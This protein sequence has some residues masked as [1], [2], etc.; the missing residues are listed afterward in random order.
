VKAKALRRAEKFREAAAV[1]ARAPRD[2]ASLVR[3]DEWWIERRLV[4]RELLDAG[5][6]K[7]A[8][9]IAAGYAAQ[10]DQTAMEAEFHAGWI[11]LRFLGDG[12]L[13]ARHF[14]NLRARAERPISV[15]RGAYWQG[16]AAEMMGDR[17]GAERYYHEAAS[18]STTYYGQI[19]RARLGLP[20]VALRKLP[21]PSS[22]ARA[23][24][25]GLLATRSIEMLY[26]LNEKDLARALVA[27]MA[28]MLQEG[29]KLAML[30]DLTL[31]EKDTRAALSVGKSATQRGFPLE[32]IAFPTAG[33]P[34]FQPLSDVEKAVVFGIARQESEFRH[35]AVSGAGARGLMQ[36]MPATARATA[37]QA[38]VTY[39]PKRL[40]TDLAYNAQI[41][42][43]HLAELIGNF[44]GSYIMTFAAYDAGSSRVSDWVATYGDPRDPA[45]DPI[46]WVER[47][48][49]TE[50][51]NYVQRVMENVQV[52]RARLGQKAVLIETDLRRGAV[53]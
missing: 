22:G 32:S 17:A 5:D 53:Q 43:A 20:G 8:Y 1:L 48:P 37:K 2:A 46:D 19:A 29:E 38:G 40:T 7:S 34:Q 28:G 31:R 47:I 35:D 14:A 4:A 44:R 18:H 21:E 39:D 45:I 41:G 36:V 25:N 52:Y 50:T 49:F 24:F 11:A 26:D 3:P 12:K 42:S 16:R 23:T 15:A 6:P 10:T 33:I 27:D 13:A 9:A 51:R 30:G